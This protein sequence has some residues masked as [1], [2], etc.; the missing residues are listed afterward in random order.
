MGG[1]R[2][3]DAQPEPRVR[4]R[5][6][7]SR[8]VPRKVNDRVDEISG[9]LKEC[10]HCAE[11]IPTAASKCRYCGEFLQKRREGIGAFAGKHTGLI[12]SLGLSSVVLMKVLLVAHYKTSTALTLLQEAGAAQ[13]IMGQLLTLLPMLL[14]GI[15]VAGF[16]YAPGQPGTTHRKIAKVTSLC[17]LGLGVL[18]LSWQV[19]ILYGVLLTGVLVWAAR[20]D[21]SRFVQGVAV[22]IAT[23]FLVALLVDD[24][25]WLPPE[26]LEVRARDS[27]VGYVVGDQ[28]GWTTIMGE[29]HREVLKVRT[30]SL[31]SRRVCKL[32]AL[33]QRN[34]S[35]LDVSQP[36]PLELV[37][38]SD[39]PQ[40][41][42]C[43]T[44]A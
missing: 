13:V 43:P 10:P 14:M 38:F 5:P 26:A 37:F 41:P 16:V 11:R 29:A 28:G 1:D 32:P 34:W 7:R 8:P 24:H 12:V 39:D 25:V 31:V 9:E 18:L 33:I 35:P 44:Q 3:Q 27:L 15:G 2:G 4:R 20:R 36:S 6:Q 40:P 42:L 22:G 30:D 23:T 17:I 21:E 19:A